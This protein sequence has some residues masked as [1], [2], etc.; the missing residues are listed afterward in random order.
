MKRIS[1]L[2]FLFVFGFTFSQEQ[3]NQQ[4]PIVT[5]RPN[6]SASPLTV[7][8]KML[9]I[10]S[11]GSYTSFEENNLKTE[12]YG[13]N[14]TLLRYGILDDF[15]FRLGINFQETRFTSNSTEAD[16]KFSGFTPLMAGIK[17]EITDEDG[18]IPQLGLLGHLYL[19]FSAGSDYR[20][21]TTGGDFLFAFSNTLSEKSGLSYNLGAQWR[22]DSPEVAYVYTLSYG[23]AITDK[24]SLFAEVY[25]NFPEDSKANHFWDA[26][27]TYLLKPN[28]QLDAVVGRSITDGQDIFLGAGASFRIPK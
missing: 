1:I 24:V 11:G 27:I 16:D 18:W 15:E 5:E 13:Y 23:Y 17:V 7:P 4:A 6:A 14:T 25:G 2:A 21:E 9:Q 28:I 3:D 22:D 12:T 20:P 26:G 10:E 19:P 8:K